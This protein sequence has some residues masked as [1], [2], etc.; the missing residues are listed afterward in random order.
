MLK[1]THVEL[2]LMV[3]QFIVK[4]MCGGVIYSAQRHSKAN[5]KYMKLSDK[6][7]S[8]ICIIYLHKS[9]LYGSGMI[10]YLPTDG[11]K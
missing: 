5:N 10:Q 9:G 2:D 3:D 11:F 6:N 8:S 7:N 4:G 1:M